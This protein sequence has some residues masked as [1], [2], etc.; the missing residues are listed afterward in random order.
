MKYAP[1]LHERLQ[2]FLKFLRPRLTSEETSLEYLSRLRALEDLRLRSHAVGRRHFSAAELCAFW[3]APE[4]GRFDVLAKEG[5]L[6]GRSHLESSMDLLGPA[7]G[8]LMESCLALR[9]LGTSKMKQAV[10]EFV[11][12]AGRALET[13]PPNRPAETP[14][15]VPLPPTLQGRRKALNDLWSPPPSILRLLDRL[16][17]PHS[18]PSAIAGEIGKEPGLP[19]WLFR[20]R[21]ALTRPSSPPVGNAISPSEYP[22]LRRLLPAAALLSR[23]D[24]PS[25]SPAFD[26]NAFWRHALETAYAARLAG[27]ASGY[28]SPETLFLTGLLHDLGRL[29]VARRLPDLYESLLSPSPREMQALGTS[30]AEIGA[31]WAERW[32]LGRPVSE[33]ARHHH[34]PP[35]ALE[36]VELSREAA[37]TIAF[38]GL[39]RAGAR[40][41]DWL[42]FLGGLGESR[43]AEIRL[44]AGRLAED[45]RR[46]FQDGDP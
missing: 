31:C 43:L 1:S 20:L 29:I 45:S 3:A 17:L 32:G 23:L 44:Q 36:D 25:G 37:T 4:T 5:G 8:L 11:R 40:P 12:Q 19:L 46:L 18:L 34:T 7:T 30:H 39:S 26:P 9:V 10:E 13:G 27:R 6:L 15:A 41:G 38:C 2:A 42:P 24:H 16:E 14:A 33:A 35:P 22:L 21:G 28:G